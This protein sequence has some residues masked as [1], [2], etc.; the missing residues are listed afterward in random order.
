CSEQCAGTQRPRRLSPG[1]RPGVQCVRC[2]Y[3]RDR[4]CARR[5]SERGRHVAARAVGQER[6][7]PWPARTKPDRLTGPHRAA[8]GSEPER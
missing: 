4:D 7:C 6:T 3:C 8:R 1:H 5:R 2:R